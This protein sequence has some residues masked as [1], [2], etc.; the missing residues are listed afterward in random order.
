M[1]SIRYTT[2][3]LLGFALLGFF[4]VSPL[5]AQSTNTYQIRRDVTVKGATVRD[6][7]VVDREFTYIPVD[8]VTDVFGAN[9]FNFKEFKEFTVRNFGNYVD[10]EFTTVPTD[11]VIMFQLREITN[12]IEKI[13]N[14]KGVVD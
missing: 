7:A 4:C 14:I 1:K 5:Q 8:R 10:K 9:N 6:T 11:A 13:E 2:L 3:G 12:R